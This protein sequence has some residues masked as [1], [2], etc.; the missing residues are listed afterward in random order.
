MLKGLSISSGY[1]LGNVFC[2]KRHKLEDIE[3]CTI[4]DADIPEELEKFNSAI[5]LSRAEITQF[6]ELPQIKSSTEISN[7]F[8]AHLT[9]LD[10][11]ELRK[12]VEKRIKNQKKD[13]LS[14]VSKVIKEYSEFFRNLPDPQFQSKAI[15]I[16]DVGKR[17]IKNCQKRGSHA[18]SLDEFEDGAIVAADDLTPSEVVTFN[19]EKIKGIVIEEGTPTAHASILA[20]SLGIPALIQVSGLMEH[21]FDN[22]FAIIDSANHQLIVNPDADTKKR[23]EEELKKYEET[24]AKI[25][26]N[27]DK[28]SIT[29]DGVEIMLKANIGQ[30]SD[31]DCA[32]ANNAYGVGLYRTEFAY[33]TR[34]TFPTENELFESYSEALKKLN[35]KR[36]VIRTID[37]GGDKISHLMGNEL[38]RNPELGWRAVRISLDCEDVFMTQLRA[39]L[40]VA[41]TAEEDAVRVLFPMIS[42]IEELRKIKSLLS[43]AAKDLTVAGVLHREKIKIGIMVEVPSVALLAD[44]F[45]KEVD[46]FA[47]GSNDLVQYTLAVDRTNSKVSHLYQ[48]ANPAVINL[49]KNIVGAGKKYNLPISICGEIAGDTRYTVL[50][51]GL[52]LRELSMNSVLIPAVKQIIRSI[53]CE[54]VEKA[55]APLLEMDTADEI[56]NALAKINASFGLS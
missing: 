23:Y 55:V 40:R 5:E 42:N 56:E 7:I 18:V 24:H 13:A 34:T 12:D 28:P 8:R 21:V 39:I 19:P 45:A 31:I 46:F 44:R 15:D 2:V 4:S 54:E 35:G 17:L 11:P 27:I 26:G 3:S 29:K 41:G 38:E 43:Q 48:P 30:I 22:D 9:L 53:S 37:V 20:R 16:L 51:V 36:I 47:I 50:L 52:G 33:L 6:L 49:I 14:V 1:A 10:D 32:L 25:M